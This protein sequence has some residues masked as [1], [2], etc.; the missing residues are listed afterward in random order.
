[1][2]L[3]KESQNARKIVLESEMVIKMLPL[4]CVDVT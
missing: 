2:L 4:K 1:M 3:I